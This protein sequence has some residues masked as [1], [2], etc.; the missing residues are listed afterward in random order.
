MLRKPPKGECA[1][2]GFEYPLPTL[3]REWTGLMVCPQDFD[4]RP[5]EMRS[6]RVSPEGL[7]LKIVAPRSEP[8]F[9]PAPE[10]IIVE[11]WLFEDG[12]PMLFEDGEV[13]LEEAA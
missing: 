10:P 7:P 11:G 1:R 4:P 2:C 8:V 9:R 5:A 13:M 12:T 6:P 3:R